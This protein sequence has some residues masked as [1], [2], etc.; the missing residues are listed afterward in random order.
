MSNVHTSIEISVNDTQNSL[1]WMAFEEL[2]LKKMSYVNR[3][4]LSDVG[5]SEK[6]MWQYCMVNSKIMSLVEFST[7]TC[8]KAPN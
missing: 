3:S 1:I 6:L 4:N 2:N 8:A 7:A 5:N